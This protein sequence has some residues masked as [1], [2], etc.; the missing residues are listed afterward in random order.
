MHVPVEA[1]A[2]REHRRRTGEFRLIDRLG[3]AVLIQC[4][5]GR[6]KWVRDGM[7]E[8]RREIR[9]HAICQR[10]ARRREVLVLRVERELADV[11][12]LTLVRAAADHRVEVL[13]IRIRGIGGLE[14][15]GE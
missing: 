6:R 11:D 5:E 7:R 9:A 4:P 13:A 8:I 1:D 12:E 10:Q 3:L 15:F 2:W 14:E